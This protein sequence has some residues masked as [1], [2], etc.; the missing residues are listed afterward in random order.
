MGPWCGVIFSPL[1]VMHAA[2]SGWQLRSVAVVDESSAVPDSP[3][4][5]Q[6]CDM[7]NLG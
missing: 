2:M 4:P 5:G 3:Y 6:S 1:R 7:D